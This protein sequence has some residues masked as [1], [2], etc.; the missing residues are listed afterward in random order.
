MSRSCPDPDDAVRRWR[1]H[2]SAVLIGAVVPVA[3]AA[4]SDDGAVP[5]ASRWSLSG[6]GSV[7][8]V[9][10]SGAD[11]LRLLRSSGQAA[12]D[13]SAS[14]LP[15]SRLGLQLNWSQ[16]TRWDGT[17]QAVAMD[18]PPG[19]SATERIEWA[20]IGYRPDPNARIRIGR[21]NADMFLYADSRNVGFA[22]PWVRPPVDFYGFAP[23]AA[24]DG[25]DV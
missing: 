20:S 7:G 1:A 3:S 21:T 13:G 6:F 4:P 11:G 5:D 2:R 25:I 14:A 17:L 24:M 9:A 8:V 15:D 12:A 16:G 19:A 23:L 10:Q 18:M 22:L